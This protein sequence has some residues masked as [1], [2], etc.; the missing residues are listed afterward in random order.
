MRLGTRLDSCEQTTAYCAN[1]GREHVMERETDSQETAKDE[2]L[3][4]NK[5]GWL[6]SLGSLSPALLHLFFLM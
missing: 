2:T 4:E 5:M 1:A 3:F 6:P